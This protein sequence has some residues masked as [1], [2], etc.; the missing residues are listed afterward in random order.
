MNLKVVSDG[1]KKGTFVIDSET[2]DPLDNLEGLTFTLISNGTGVLELKVTNV[3]LEILVDG[4]TKFVW[5]ETFHR[6]IV[7]DK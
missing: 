7:G 3:P 6:F 2:G 4:D 1:T 5:K